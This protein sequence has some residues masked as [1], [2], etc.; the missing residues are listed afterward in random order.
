MS[1][2]HEEPKGPDLTKG[3]PAADVPEGGMLTGQVGDE[4]VLVARVDGE[5]FAIGGSCTHYHGPLG[6]GL[7]VGHTVRC[8]WH[9]GHF[10]LR[11]GEAL[12][13][14]PID[15]VAVWKPEERDG[16]I[17]V[18]SGA[19]AKNPA[20]KARAAKAPR[21]ILIAG[22]GA[23]GFAAAEMLRRHG[24][25]GALHLVSS[26]ADAPYDR[27]NCSKDFLAGEAPAEWMPLREDGWYKDHDID[28]RLKT[29]IT[30]LDLGARTASLKAGDDL[31]YDALVLALGAE[32]QRP[33]IP[34]FDSPKV[35]TLRSLKDAQAIA[36]AAKTAH[37]VA[38][39]GASF[40][41]LEVA[42]SLK[43][44]G[45]DVHVVAPEAIP[46]ARVLGDAVGE[47]IRGLHEAKGVVFHLGRKVQGFKDG[48]LG[49]DNGEAIEADFVV[50]GAGVRPRTALAEAAGLKVDN[51]VVVDRWLRAPADNVYAVGDIARFPD[52]HTGK[53]IRVE[54][55][56]HAERQGQHVAR[57]LLGDDAAFADTP[58]FW[59]VHQGKT[60]NY[61]GHA[62]EFDQP[63]IQG[64]LEKENAVI[65]FAKDGRDLAMATVGD[66]L[67]SLKAGRTFEKQAKPA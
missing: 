39:V 17:F 65:C 22:G 7:L 64:S 6:E 47:W 21:R 58:F 28:L 36:A 62:D 59:S 12:A 44:L 55:W 45:L 40:I 26:D 23:A 24:Y 5:L 32:P 25:D 8:P 35:F 14:P 42:A 4:T 1:D 29:E 16:K 34:G 11:T 53:V 46:L 50:A 2:D 27:P 63:K 52:A 54:H 19:E 18:R 49:L 31:G 51:G 38:I 30:R 41:G 43:H 57:L 37:R 15:P 67:A 10:C 48:K 13:G 60:I 33:P 56:V 66:D 20:P 9:H 3:V 61:V